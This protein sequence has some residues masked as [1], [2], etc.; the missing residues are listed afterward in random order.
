MRAHT[1]TLQSP[2]QLWLCFSR[3][4]SSSPEV[5]SRF[6]DL[7]RFYLHSPDEWEWQLIKWPHFVGSP[8]FTFPIQ[9]LRVGEGTGNCGVYYLLLGSFKL[10]HNSELC[11]RMDW[12]LPHL[13]PT[14][15]T[16][17]LPRTR[18]QHTF[19]L[20]QLHHAIL[21]PNNFRLHAL[22]MPSESLSIILWCVLCLCFG[23]KPC[24]ELMDGRKWGDLK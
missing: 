18:K 10:K 3:N 11:A 9:N 5:F 24:P 20:H 1:V 23:H 15:L 12:C 2:T 22:I 16:K 21:V 17:W 14:Q 13:L 7:S 19:Y 6:R 8:Q 4:G